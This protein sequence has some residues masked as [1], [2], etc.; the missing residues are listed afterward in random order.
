MALENLADP[1]VWAAV[2]AREV[3][4]DLEGLAAFQ[5]APLA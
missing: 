1:A 3:A 5:E 4:S 2:A